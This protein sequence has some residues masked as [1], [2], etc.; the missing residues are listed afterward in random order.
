[1]EQKRI[2]RYGQFKIYLGKC[3]RLFLTEKK[4]TSFLST[5]I[6]MVIISMVTSE[7]MFIEYADTRNGAFAIICAC[8]WI[9]LFNSIQ[10]ICRERAIIKREHRTGL[11]ISSYIAAHAVYELV[12]CA[13]EA[14]IVELALWVKN[15]NTLPLDGFIIQQVFM[16]YAVLL[17]TI[18]SSD[19]LAL[20]ISSIVK[21][22]T[23]AMT[24]MPFVLII[25]LVM[26][27]SVFELK[28]IARAISYFTI[29]KWGLNCVCTIANINREVYRG[30]SYSGNDG[31]DP[32]WNNFFMIILILCAFSIL[33]LG[34]SI[35]ALERVD[36]DQR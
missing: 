32:T 4:W 28:G 35:A 5:L 36:R 31:C 29:S 6:I 23:M 24:I 10:S 17:L 11:H 20:V 25:Q 12:V 8:I 30:Y 15:W 21:T 14:M 16:L 7:D 13:C 34:L 27:G 33:F 9:G 3:F 2:S 18:F 19:C 1:V 26:S 22:E